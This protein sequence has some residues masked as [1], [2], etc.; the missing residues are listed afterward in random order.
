MLYAE[1]GIPFY[2]I[3][4][5]TSRTIEAFQLAGVNY[6]AAGRVATTA[7]A[8]LPLNDLEIDPAALWS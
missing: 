3:V 8:L 2:W 1:L 4:D 5:P 7:S 6:E